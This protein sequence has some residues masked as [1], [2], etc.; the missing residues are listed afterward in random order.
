MS[1]ENHRG[2]FHHAQ[3]QIVRPNRSSIVSFQLLESPAPRWR[4]NA[5]TPST[6]AKT[7]PQKPRGPDH[8]TTLLGRYHQLGF[9]SASRTLRALVAWKAREYYFHREILGTHRPVGYFVSDKMGSE[10]TG[11]SSSFSFRTDAAETIRFTSGTPSQT[12]SPREAL[13]LRRCGSQSRSRCGRWCQW[14]EPPAVL[15]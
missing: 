11:C 7:H 3:D 12:P 10:P 9:L 2:S 15:H 13:H 6:F 14:F 1:S 5:T 8:F 4:D